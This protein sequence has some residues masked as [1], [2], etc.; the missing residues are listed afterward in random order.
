MPFTFSHP[1][2]ILPFG[3]VGKRYFSLTA[4]IIGSTT[5][6]FEYFL[7]LRVRSDFSHTLFG[8]FWFDLP[9]GIALCFVFH[10]LVKK[11]LFKNLPFFLQTRFNDCLGFDFID[12]FKKHF[13]V[14]ISSLLLGA[15]SHLFWDGFTHHYG[16]FVELFSVLQTKT[17]FYSIPVFKILQHLST[18]LGGICIALWVYKLP[19]TSEIVYSISFNYWFSVFSCFVFLFF[20]RILLMYYFQESFHVGN[21][22]VSGISLMLLSLILVGTFEEFY[23]TKNLK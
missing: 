13:L 16:F 9:L 6:D 18:L 15:F 22:I 11:S 7:R 5:P 14:V 21:F 12:Y 20:I 10:L 23:T 2:I 3:F 8:V 4:L 17:I 19:K 1:A